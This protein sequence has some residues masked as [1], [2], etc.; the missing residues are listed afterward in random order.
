MD[1]VID[2]ALFDSKVLVENGV[3]A[4][5]VEN[6]GDYPYYPITQEPETVAAMT[7]VALEIRRKYPDTPLGINVLQEQFG[8][9]RLQLH[10][11]LEQSLF[12]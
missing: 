3:T 8:K 7:R 5:I 9:A 10:I 4:L 6:L 1:D 12:D 11:W 2:H